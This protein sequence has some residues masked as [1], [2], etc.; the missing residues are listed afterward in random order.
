MSKI[1]QNNDTGVN[2]VDDNAS[3]MTILPHFL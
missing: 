3:A 1:L 2:I